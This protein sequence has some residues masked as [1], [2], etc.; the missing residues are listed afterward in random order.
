[1]VDNKSNKTGATCGALTAYP[2]GAHAFTPDFNGA[3]VAQSLGL[4]AMFYRSL[5]VLFLLAIVFSVLS[6]FTASDYRFDFFKPF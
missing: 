5:F 4:C 6:R 3:R 2:S 1:M